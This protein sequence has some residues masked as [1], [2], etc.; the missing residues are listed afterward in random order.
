MIKNERETAEVNQLL[1]KNNWMGKNI[2][3]I[4]LTDR[5]TEGEFVWESEGTVMDYSNWMGGEP[6]GHAESDD[7]CV[8][9]D[10]EIEGRRWTDRDCEDSWVHA[11]CQ[12]GKSLP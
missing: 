12:I 5:L 8:H 10:Y 3:W 6:N 1:R 9:T 11:L 4:G 7:D 2:Y